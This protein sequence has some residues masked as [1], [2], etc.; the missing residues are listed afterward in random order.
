LDPAEDN[1]WGPYYRKGAPYRAKVTPPLA[2]GL[3]LLVQGR[4]W[5]ADTR[6]PLAGASLDVWQADH[7]GH[8]DNEDSDRPRAENLFVNRARL[9]ADESGYYEYETVHPGAY[10]T[11]PD[12]WRPSHVHYFVGHAGYGPLVTQ[13]YFK[14]DPHNATDEFIKASLII[15]TQRRRVGKQEYEAG[16]FDIVLSPV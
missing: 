13:L 9:V 4:V 7:Q 3:V 14:G 15:E 5:G 12:T 1:I 16:V 8:Y 6:K 11:G 2:A 10:K